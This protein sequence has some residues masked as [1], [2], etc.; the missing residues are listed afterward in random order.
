[1]F[2][3]GQDDTGFLNTKIIKNDF[4]DEFVFTRTAQGVFSCP[5]FLKNKMLYSSSIN[6]A[7]AKFVWDESQQF[8]TLNG[9]N[10]YDYVFEFGGFIKIERYFTTC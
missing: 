3:G 2:V 9:D 5:Q 8:F 6:I 10:L 7:N 1:M 4:D